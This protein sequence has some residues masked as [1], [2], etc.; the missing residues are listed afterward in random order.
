MSPMEE[1]LKQVIDT[2]QGIQL[3]HD[4][5]HERRAHERSNLMIQAIVAF[6]AVITLGFLMYQGHNASISALVEQ[7]KKSVEQSIGFLDKRLELID[8]RLSSF[9]N[10][11]AEISVLKTRVDALE[12]KP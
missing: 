12:R 5:E 6:T 1:Q 10:F 8:A 9:Q 7:Q 11:Q 4:A 2:V 3:A